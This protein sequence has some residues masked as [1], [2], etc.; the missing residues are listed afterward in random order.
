MWSRRREETPEERD[1]RWRAERA[2]DELRA[3]Q[4]R[5]QREAQERRA[6][7]QSEMRERIWEYNSTANTWPEALGKN[8]YRFRSEAGLDD[9]TDTFFGDG[10]DACAF[11]LKAWNRISETREAER[12]ELQRRLGQIETEVKLAVASEIRA[13]SDKPGWVQVAVALEDE[14]HTPSDFLN[15]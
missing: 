4:E 1:L 15:W 12:E 6:Q 7:R 9:E 8:E 10:A 3:Q 13:K 2:E 11:A 14:D 5:T